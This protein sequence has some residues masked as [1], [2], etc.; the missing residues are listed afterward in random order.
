MKTGKLVFKIETTLADVD[1]TIELKSSEELL[2]DTIKAMVENNVLAHNIKI[3][4]DTDQR[5][6]EL[7]DLLKKIA[8]FVNVED[9]A[10]KL[11]WNILTAL[12][13]PDV[14]ETFN[15]KTKTTS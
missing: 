12:R 3:E 15:L 5:K 4:D 7:R 10:A 13:G 14:D 6:Q 2:V 1:N 9:S 11:L 8:D